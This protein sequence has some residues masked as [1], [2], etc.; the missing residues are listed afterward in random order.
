MST[1]SNHTKAFVQCCYG[2][3]TVASSRTLLS[4]HVEEFIGSLSPL[5]VIKFINTRDVVEV[6]LVIA[7]S[8]YNK[9]CN[10]ITIKPVI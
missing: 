4:Y 5:T 2:K 3:H 7:T 1:S 9:I 10:N 8:V 6:Q